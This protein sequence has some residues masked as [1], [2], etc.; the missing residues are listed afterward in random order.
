[1]GSTKPKPL[2]VGITGL[3]FTARGGSVNT[4][5]SSYRLG[6]IHFAGWK[7]IGASGQAVTNSTGS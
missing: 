1:M 5:A 3:P 6:M 7:V 4:M 2:V